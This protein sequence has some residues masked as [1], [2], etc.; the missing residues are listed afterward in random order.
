MRIWKSL[1]PHS[2]SRGLR[3]EVQTG[4]L[5]SKSSTV[6][7]IATKYSSFW[8][9][10]NLDCPIR[11]PVW[12]SNLHWNLMRGLGSEVPGMSATPAFLPIWSAAKPGESMFEF[13][14][15]FPDLDLD[16]NS[17]RCVVFRVCA[18]AFRVCVCV[19]VCGMRMLNFLFLQASQRRLKAARRPKSGVYRHPPSEFLLPPPRHEHAM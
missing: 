17:E 4:N 13:E 14:V 15:P 5:T 16:A 8:G 11:V 2:N 6:V 10:S 19:C 9:R 1:P 7:G 18:R 3:F 12:V